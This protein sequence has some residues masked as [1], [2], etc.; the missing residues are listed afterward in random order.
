MGQS[1]VKSA[2]DSKNS[3]VLLSVL[4]RLKLAGDRGL[5]LDRIMTIAGFSY[6]KKRS[7]DNRLTKAAYGNDFLLSKLLKNKWV[8][9]VDRPVW[10]QD[11]PPV[12]RITEKGLSEQITLKER[13]DRENDRRI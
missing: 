2:I 5:A 6:R 8:E 10:A 3:T 12:Y 4:S 13:I 11:S 7:S 1:P 9:E